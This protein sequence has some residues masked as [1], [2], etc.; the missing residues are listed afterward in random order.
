MKS[1]I[2][3]LKNHSYKVDKTAEEDINSVILSYAELFSIQ[4]VVHDWGL[5]EGTMMAKAGIFFNDRFADLVIF[6]MIFRKLDIMYVI[7]HVLDSI[8]HTAN[9]SKYFLCVSHGFCPIWSF[10]GAPE[11]GTSMVSKYQVLEV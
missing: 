1:G 4:V 9:D 11:E 8:M 7:W 10:N 2:R 6:W 3:W 5:F